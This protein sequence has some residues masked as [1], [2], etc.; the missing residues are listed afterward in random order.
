MLFA[1]MIE[2]SSFFLEMQTSALDRLGGFQYL[3][4]LFYLYFSFREV[5]NRSLIRNR[6]DGLVGGDQYRQSVA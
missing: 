6:S 5:K 3:T 2:R 1:V 4:A